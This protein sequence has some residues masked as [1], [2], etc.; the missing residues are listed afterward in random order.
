MNCRSKKYTFMALLMGSLL[1][2]GG[3]SQA[4]QNSTPESG[5]SSS[6]STSAADDNQNGDEMFTDRDKEIGYEEST[7]IA[8]SL[9]DD[10]IQC[11][12]S[13][14]EISGSTVTIKDEGT[15]L[16]SGSLSNGQIIIEADKKA[17][18]QL[19]LDGVSINC[20][21]SAAIYVK[22]ADKVFITTAGNTENTLSNKKEFSAID[23]NNIDSVIFSKEDLT[24]NGSGTLAIN[25]AYGHG[26]VS[27]DD[28][29]LTSGTYQIT[30]A[31]H[32]L[33]GKD[34]VRI[35]DGDFT[36][37]SG[38]DGIHA[39]NSDDSSLGFTYIAGGSFDITSEGDGIDASSYLQLEK[40]TFN[41]KSGGG[42]AN[43]EVKQEEF[44]PGGRMTQTDSDTDTDTASAKGIKS[45][46]DLTI[47]GGTFTIDSADDA[48]HSNSGVTINDGEFTI[49]TGDDGIHADAGT[50]VSGGNITITESYEGIEGMTIDITG[51][52]ISVTSSDDGL[53]AAGGNDESGFGGGMKQDEFAADSNSYIK[54][55]GGTINIDASGDGIDSNGNLYIS[56][57]E[58]YVSGPENSGNGALDYNGDAEITGGIIIAAGE[59][60]MAQNF[61]SNSTQGS[62]LVNVSSSNIDGD[63]ILKDSSGNELV[64]YTPKKSYNSVVISCPEIKQNETYTVT[65]GGQDT[66]VEMTSLIYG[67]G[68]MGGGMGGGMRDNNMPPGGG[69]GQRDDAPF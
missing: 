5:S 30:A 4:E 24:L 11:N 55:S 2:L 28:L 14:V 69:R 37:T 50:A 22:Q 7:A 48:I 44:F 51:G 19:V 53:N 42:S 45:S 16:L 27:K 63:I 64:K 41:I 58:T 68:G 20:D 60:G 46:G 15:Y 32:A 65:A 62:M 23:D 33:S 66:S 39:E 49:S 57:G 54:I 9:S 18:L 35:A 12:S 40:G 10:K 43:A 31:S 61:G 21:T 17:K 34:S 13:N 26:I 38:K 3:C 47:T 25:A 52:T 56:G 1:L 59:N 8:V 6:A 67:S 29:K 36:L